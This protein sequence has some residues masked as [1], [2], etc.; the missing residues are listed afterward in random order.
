M[1][2]L[3]VAQAL[4]P[5]GWAEQ[6]RL[7]VD[8]AGTITRVEADA[9]PGRAD[10]R[11]AGVAVPGLPNLHSHAFQR[12]LAGLTERRGGAAEDS[13]WSWREV[14]YGFLARL[15]PD[16]VEAIATQLYVEMLRAGYTAVAEFH[17]LHRTPAGTSYADPAEMSRRLLSAARRSGIGMTLVPAVYTSGDFGAAPLGEAQKRFRMEPD[18]AA[19]LIEALAPDFA[20]APEGGSRR[21]GLALHSLRAVPPAAL[22]EALAAMRSVDADA[23]VHIHAAEQRREVE[24]CLAW[25]GARPV[26]WLLDNADV[27]ARWC[28]VHATHV[29]PDEV[30]RLAATRAVAGLCPTTEANLGD[31]LFPLRDY[32]SAGG[33]FGVGSDSHVSVSPVEELRWLEYGQ[34][35]ATGVRNVAGGFPHPSTGRSLFEGAAAGAA[36][37]LGIQA[38]ALEVGRRA[39]LVVLD[40]EHPTLAGRR[41][42][43]LLDSW[44]FAGNIPAVRHVLVGGRWVVRDG[45]HALEQKV[46]ERYRETTRRLALRAGA[47]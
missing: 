44:V 15:D 7:S 25:S 43:A 27:D 22:Q 12:A 13:F 37:A 41:G 10:E 30:R 33:A 46:L 11:V 21:L 47:V 28:L 32:L 2:D 24:A 4:L 6:V 16:D 36:R 18:G 40:P 26:E 19:A 17:Y 39:D 42:D 20:R 9:P 34:R 45:H 35:L 38:G 29:S 1:P 31:G 5:G 8:A 3:L 14:M 23:P